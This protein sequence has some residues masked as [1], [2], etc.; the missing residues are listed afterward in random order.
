MSDRARNRIP[1]PEDLN[2]LLGALGSQPIDGT[3]EPQPEMIAARRASRGGKNFEEILAEDRARLREARYPGSECL[4]PYEVERYFLGSLGPERTA[5]KDACADCAALLE[6]AMPS[7]GGVERIVEEV[8]KTAEELGR[9]PASEAVHAEWWP[10]WLPAPQ[11]GLALIRSRSARG[12][13]TDA[14]AATLPV[15]F[16]VFGVVLF[17][18]FVRPFPEGL[19]LATIV[20]QPWVV[21]I[22]AAVVLAG[23]AALVLSRAEAGQAVLRESAGALAAG[24]MLAAAGGGFLWWNLG[25]QARQTEVRLN[26]VSA[27]LVEAVAAS[28]A[29]RRSTGTFPQ[30]QL[31]EGLLALTT[32]QHAT[33]RAIYRAETKGLKGAVVANVDTNGGTVYWDS[34]GV[35]G[36]IASLVRGRIEIVT[37]DGFVLREQRGEALRIKAPLDP[38]RKP[39]QEVVAIFDRRA[40]T[41]T[42]VYPVA[43][44]MPILQTP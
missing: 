44:A 10:S 38:T 12:F 42:G 15:L 2:E 18:R 41:A 28:F 11:S 19:D 29:V 37:E 17:Y 1:K 9:V 21:P 27:R 7:D 26:L 31:N 6:G 25:E 13:L 43:R 4:E 24:I 33:D 20:L 30:V 35:S 8:R 14:L 3:D 39:G 5:H 23:L 32:T 22:I 36:Q 16:V 40:N 34:A